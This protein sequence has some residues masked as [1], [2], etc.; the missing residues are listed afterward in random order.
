MFSIFVKGQAQEGEIGPPQGIYLP[1]KAMGHQDPYCQH[2]Q[3]VVPLLVR[4]PG[5]IPAG[6]LE[7]FGDL[8]GEHT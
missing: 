4:H 7:K 3:I 1:S 5:V 6:D 8:G 2:T